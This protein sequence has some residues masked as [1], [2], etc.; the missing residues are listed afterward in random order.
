LILNVQVLEQFLNLLS[1]KLKIKKCKWDKERRFTSEGS[2]F[3]MDI[4]F[5][6]NLLWKEPPS[7][8][9]YARNLLERNLPWKELPSEG[10]FLGRN[11]YNSTLRI[12]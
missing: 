8:R 2:S 5:G 7:E 3:Q 4:S 1:E 12:Y 6:W 11:I 10:T 9:T